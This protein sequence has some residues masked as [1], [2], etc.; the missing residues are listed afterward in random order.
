[1]TA[2]IL[3]VEDD[4]SLREALGDTLQLGG[5]EHRAV[6]CA[7]AALAALQQ[8]PFG[9]V[10][11]DVN[12]PGMDGHALLGV[13]RQRHPQLPVLLMTAF[14]AVAR[15]VDAMR[16]G[17]ADYL[18]KPFEPK[19]LLDLLAQHVN[20]RLGAGEPEG[21]VA[22]E[23]ASQQLLGLAARVAQSDST[24][25]ISG[26]SGTGKE[27]L[28]RYIH[29]QSPRAARPFIAIN[30][31]AIPD[32]ML[33]AT[34]F[35]HEKGAFTGAIASQPGKFEL[36][37][38]GTLLLDEISEMPLALQ[39]KLLRV[40]QEREVERVGA[41]KPITLDIRVLATTNRDLA[42]EVAAGRFREDLF[43]RLSVFPLAWS[44]LRQRPADILPLAERLLASHARKM[45]Q[46]A[47][48]LSSEAQR[49]LLEHAWPGNVRELDNAIQRALILQQGGQIQPHD[50]CLGASIGLASMPATV[51]PPAPAATMPA[52]PIAEAG[53]VLGEDLRRREF[54]LIIDTLRAERGR[55]KETADRLGISARTLR[56]KLAQM[57]DA[58]MDVEASLY[59][60]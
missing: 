20:G 3:L 43:Y 26:E 54:Q 50:L 39:A 45:H 6:D 17:A 30:C 60:G 10:I 2:K 8:E 18:V 16:Q 41:R 51:M 53:G 31:A 48:R 19:T 9:L 35:G 22:C 47:P 25:L 33:E 46:I 59:A 1:M 57:R 14:G 27:V 36:A 15:A 40:L 32:N 12:M 52:A 42:G 29:Q 55:R 37:D 13:I 4:R 28:A 24:V 44:P 49:C 21:P 11:S 56:Y 5:Y 34:L 38:G 23:P 58:G 7:E